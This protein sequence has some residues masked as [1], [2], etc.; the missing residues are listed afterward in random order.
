MDAI[1]DAT[2]DRWLPPEVRSAR[3]EAEERLREMFLASAPEGYAGCCEAI[4][5]MDL[6]GALGSIEAPTLV[7][8]GD[9]DP[10]TPADRVR[11][12]ADAIPGAHFVEI[13]GAAHIAN[14]A[15][16]EAFDRVVLQHLGG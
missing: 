12:V 7:V 9:D 8:A 10:S 1:V 3:P 4:R 6:R 2:M 13:A 11:Q 16:P 15:Q 14:V 5:D